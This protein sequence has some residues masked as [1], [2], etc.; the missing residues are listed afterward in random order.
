MLNEAVQQYKSNILRWFYLK[1]NYDS[2]IY[3]L[4][5]ACIHALKAISMYLCL[6]MCDRQQGVLDADGERV[7]SEV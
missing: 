1:R 7:Y 2:S 4:I 5:C 3:V 6:F